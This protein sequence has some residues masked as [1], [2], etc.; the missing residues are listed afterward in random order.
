MTKAI[1]PSNVRLLKFSPLTLLQFFTKRIMMDTIDE[2]SL[3]NPILF[4]LFGNAD[5]RLRTLNV[6]GQ[7]LIEIISIEEPISHENK[8]RS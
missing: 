5:S 2:T 7:V 3:E 1:T 8:T 4:Y 6:P